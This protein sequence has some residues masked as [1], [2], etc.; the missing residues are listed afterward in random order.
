[1]KAQLMKFK[2]YLLHVLIVFI[3]GFGAALVSAK[4]GDESVS[5]LAG[6]VVSAATAG[7]VAVL[8]YLSGLI[9][10]ADP[11]ADKSAS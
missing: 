8:H 7:V 2:P 6:L 1:M 5:A 3:V 4:V 9:G 11:S 10:P